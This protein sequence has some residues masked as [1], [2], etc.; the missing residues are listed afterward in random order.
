MFGDSR[1][2]A[3][4]AAPR[5]SGEEALVERRKDAAAPVGVEPAEIT[6]C[7]RHVAPFV[8]A[9][10]DAKGPVQ[11]PGRA[12]RFMGRADL[13][14]LFHRVA[15]AIRPFVQPELQENS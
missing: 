15:K 9:K 8:G 5:Q 2:E 11:Q 10:I 1:L 6:P 12:Q 7:N 13:Q 3:Q 4:P 14:Q